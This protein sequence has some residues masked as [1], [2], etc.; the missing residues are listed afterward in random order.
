MNNKLKTALAVLTFAAA[1]SYA[2]PNLLD[3]SWDALGNVGNG[4]N[5][6]LITD[7]PGALYDL[8]FAYQAYGDIPPTLYLYWPNNLPSVVQVLADPLSDGS[9]TIDI[10]NLPGSGLDEL[11]LNVEANGSP[12]AAG[13]IL[14]DFS[15]VQAPS[16]VPDAASSSALL[17]V[18]LLG[19]AGLRRKLS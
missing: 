6:Q 16:G 12:N 9:G 19:L 2:G 13:V 10:N 1:S 11:F 7:T 18:A 17:G 15:L 3:S 5:S 14:S 4:A 8:T